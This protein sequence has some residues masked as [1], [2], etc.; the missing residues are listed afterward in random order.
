MKIFIKGIGLL[1]VLML[2][3]TGC[4]SPKTEESPAVVETPAESP[5]EVLPEIPKESG[6]AQK[7]DLEGRLTKEFFSIVEGN[8]Y[9]MQYTIISDVGGEEQE[10]R[11]NFTMDGDN[12]AM[13]F[14]SDEGSSDTIV[15]DGVMY[16]VVHDER[17]VIEFPA[18][19]IQFSED[20]LSDP[21]DVDP[22]ELVFV[23]SGKTEFAG[24]MMDYEEYTGFDTTVRYFFD[25]KRL[26][27]FESL[28]DDDRSIVIVDKFE[29]GVDS[30]MFEIPSDYQIMNP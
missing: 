15:K 18:M 26:A 8:S 5:A 3:L 22:D 6:N 21:M 29:N 27:G 9:T 14:E 25:G 17:M 7:S 12:Y 16:M 24:K 30:S 2:L 11:I 13:R 23:T 1:L 10:A 20:N 4:S 28:Y 19:D